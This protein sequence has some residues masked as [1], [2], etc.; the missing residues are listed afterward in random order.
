[1]TTITP[2]AL[3]GVLLIEPQTFGDERGVFSEIYR[4]DRLADAGFATAFVQENQSLSPRRGTVRGLHFQSPPHAQDKL[5]RVISGAILDVLVDIRRRSATYGQS[6]AVELSGDNRRQLLAPK[7]FAHGFCTLTDD[8][9][10]VYKLSDFYAPAT[11]GGLLWSDRALGIDW[12]IHPAEATVN[13]RDAGWP[14]LADFN[15]PFE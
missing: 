12:P 4:A 8:C 11:E 9:V 1:V 6:V 13:D 10:V 2:L 15:S 5:I 3:P 14:A 7:G